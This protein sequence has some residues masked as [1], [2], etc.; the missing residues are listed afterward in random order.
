MNTLEG[1]HVLDL[2]LGAE[3]V[4][5][6]GTDRDVDVR[7][8]VAFFKIA[9][10]NS[11]V[12]ENFLERRQ[13]GDRLVGAGHVRLGDDL[14]ERGS[15]A[16]EVH[17]RRLCVMVDLR[18]VLFKMDVVD[19][20]EFLR[21]VGKGDFHAAADAQRI[22]VFGNLVILGHIG[23]EIV[24]AVESRVAVDLAAEHHAAHD[25]ELHGLFVH[26]RQRPGIAETYGADVGVGFA[27][28]LQETAA[29]HLGVRLELDVG[30]QSDCVF[31]F[32]NAYYTIKTNADS[33]EES[34]PSVASAMTQR[35]DLFSRGSHP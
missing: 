26:D 9:V 32:H 4:G 24:L 33:V 14:H 2:D 13:I 23:I 10:G 29:E 5:A 1:V 25:R 31:K 18:G 22:A 3:F 34:A 11:G 15:A 21:S 30:F 8:H 7:A 6:D 12:D 28:R 19:A 27:A 17:S 16:V 35:L 20:D